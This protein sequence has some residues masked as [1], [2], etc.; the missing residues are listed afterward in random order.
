MDFDEA[1]ET[2]AL[3]SWVR[4]SNGEPEP[5]GKGTVRW[6]VWRSHNFDG[7]LMIQ[8][9][10]PPR[11]MTFELEPTPTAH[12]GYTITEGGGHTFEAI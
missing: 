7:Q 5:P 3:A 10:G 8:H 11:A 6:R 4:V 12:V 2:L 1:F 9:A